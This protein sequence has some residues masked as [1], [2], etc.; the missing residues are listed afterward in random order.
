[1]QNSQQGLHYVCKEVLCLYRIYCLEWV[2]CIFS[3]R[4]GWWETGG[5]LELFISLAL[6]YTFLHSTTPT[7]LSFSLS[8]WCELLTKLYQN[9]LSPDKHLPPP[10]CWELPTLPS[11]L[12]PLS[13]R[14]HDVFVFA[15]VFVFEFV[16]LFV[17]VFVFVFEF[18]LPISPVPKN[19][20]HKIHIRYRVVCSWYGMIW[21]R[22]WFWWFEVSLSPK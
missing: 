4:G 10:L 5:L 7:D 3:Q 14:H 18:L 6:T 2:C 19:V 15:F 20:S 1:M 12:S 22:L 8:L 17:F 21:L 11:S 9:W 16:L 13:P